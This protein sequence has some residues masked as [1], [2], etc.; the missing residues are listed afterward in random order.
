MLR[1]DGGSDPDEEAYLQFT[2][3]GLTNAPSSATVRVHVGNGPQ[4]YSANGPAI[5]AAPGASWT[6]EGITWENRP[7]RPATA[8]SDHG[9]VGRNTWIDYDVTST[10]TGNGTYTFV[11]ATSSTDATE[12]DSRESGFA[13]QLILVVP[14]APSTETSAT[15][16]PQPTATPSPTSTPTTPAT[17]TVTPAPT[18]TATLAPSAT[19]TPEP[20]AT[21]TPEPT[22]TVTPEPTATTTPE[23]TAT[24][25]PELATGTVVNTNGEG[26]RCRTTPSLDGEVIT[27][28]PEGATVPVRGPQEGDWL[29][30][31][32]AGQDG[33]VMA[34]FVQIDGQ[35]SPTIAPTATAAE[36]SPSVEPTVAEA[37][38]TPTEATVEQPA[39][40]PTEVVVAAP[41]TPT[42][43]PPPAPYPIAAGW[44]SDPNTPW[45]WV[46]DNDP[47]TRW[48]AT[49]GPPPE[50]AELG[51]DLATVVAIDRL[52][53]LPTWPM[54][55]SVD[56]RLSYDGT[57]WYGMGSIA[58]D[59]LTADAWLDLPVGYTTRYVR[60]VFTNPN[61]ATS[62]GA[63]A[64]VQV[65]KSETGTG[66]SLDALPIVEPTP[67]P[68][69][70]PPPPTEAIAPAPTE[71]PTPEPVPDPTPTAEVIAPSPTP[72]DASIAP[73]TEPQATGG[74]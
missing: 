56:I 8:L 12:I 11:L 16:T 72:T 25:A 41:P 47:A 27:V 9:F 20:T 17:A 13:P 34:A 67:T 26:L 7:T 36:P 21:A 61:A 70:P 73:T 45:W 65:W 5:Y 37:A 68:A 55:G 40:T 22:V 53:W 46:T 33:Y 49:I 52:S 64:E 69:P 2:V 28:L 39:P 74:P 58:L 42:P 71:T 19:A 60:L 31:T 50:S 38:P 4:A 18:A 59:Q 63:L 35:Q 54:Q 32:C 48:S 51:L 24:G 1:I 3:S 23:P 62:V 43:T 6:E 44:Q 10:I 57:T 30:V 66:Q 14:A 29:P 15:A